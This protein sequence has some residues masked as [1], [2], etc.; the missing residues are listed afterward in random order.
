MISP[1]LAR[2]AKAIESGFSNT[3]AQEFTVDS[4]LAKAIGFFVNMPEDELHEW[5]KASVEYANKVTDLNRIK[6]QYKILFGL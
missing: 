3:S 5:S 6:Q 4:G 2:T 1:V